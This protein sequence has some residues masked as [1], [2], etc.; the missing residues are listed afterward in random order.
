[1]KKILT[2]TNILLVIIFFVAFF[3]RAYQLSSRTTFDAD[4]E[5][6]AFRAK[7]IL[8]GDLALIGP[9]T[10]VGNYSIGPYFIYLWALV[11]V[12]LN[13]DAISG[14]ILSVFCGLVSILLLFHF[15]KNVIDKKTALVILFLTSISIN[16]IRWDQSPWAP[17]MFFI[18]QIILLYG[19][20]IS[21]KK[22]YGYPIMAL[23]FVLGFSSHF[24]IVLSLLS[25]GVYLVIVRPIRLNFKYTVI[26][27]AIILLGF[28]PNI[29]FDLTHEFINTKRIIGIISESGPDYFVSF[30]KIITVL[31]N[32]TVSLI[33]PR[34]ISL[35][36]SIIKKVLFA[37]IIV[38]GIRN[39]RNKKY[40]NI[41]ILSLVTLIVPAAIFYF[42]QGKFSEYYLIMT[43]PSAFILLAIFIK[44]LNSKFS[45]LVYVALVF[46]AYLNYKD[47]T[48]INIMW[49]LK[50]K[51]TVV[52]TIIDKGGYDNY[53]ISLTTKFGQQ[54]GF[55]YILDNYKVK[56]SLPPK[57]GET[58]IFSIIIPE[59]YDGMVGMVDFDGIGL[60]WSGI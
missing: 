48:N 8:N 31:T 45:Y 57:Q 17:S 44:D 1:M 14:A 47:F 6:L 42:Q 26:T 28:L 37:L 49:N 12:F 19:A 38:N 39:I 22:L 10:S 43:I 30:N 55:K 29:T 16:L 27:S 33:Y 54:F 7:E 9:V 11:S 52:Q 32:N 25:V 46:S 13:G 15:I 40:K 56:A 20:L 23:G 21:Q 5:W 36:D 50:A 60:R 34:S 53:G 51:E 59:G 35:V 2:K 3:L 41:S 18:S 24:G 58:K 4:Q